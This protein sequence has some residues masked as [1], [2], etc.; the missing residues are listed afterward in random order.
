MINIF[1]GFFV[2]PYVFP[3]FP[4][5]AW[6]MHMKVKVGP[7]FHCCPNCLALSLHF[8][9]RWITRAYLLVWSSSSIQYGLQVIQTQSWI[10]SHTRNLYLG[11][12]QHLR[13]VWLHVAPS[14]AYELKSRL[15]HVDGKLIDPIA[16]NQWPRDKG[17]LEWW[18]EEKNNTIEL[19]LDRH[20]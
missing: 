10:T 9:D 1:R 15:W 18:D 20:Q 14:C 2:F 11:G 5:I 16:P 12:A 4:Y 6:V 17:W 8:A 3:V 13:M 7:W 19:S